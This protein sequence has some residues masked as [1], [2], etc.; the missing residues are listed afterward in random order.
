MLPCN[1][2]FL[3]GRAL[4]TTTIAM[5]RSRRNET[6]TRRLTELRSEDA[7]QHAGGQGYQEKGVLETAPGIAVHDLLPEHTQVAVQEVGFLAEES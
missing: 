1:G 2:Q 3:S 6:V 5:G 4:A 7:D